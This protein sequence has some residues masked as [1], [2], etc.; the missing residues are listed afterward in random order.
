MSYKRATRGS[1]VMIWWARV[2]GIASGGIW[3]AE[4][5]AGIWIADG[6]AGEAD[7]QLTAQRRVAAEDR[8]EPVPQRDALSLNPRRRD[9]RERRGR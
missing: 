4:G 2:C 5:L 7:G 1:R 6:Q 3:V 9:R 8:V